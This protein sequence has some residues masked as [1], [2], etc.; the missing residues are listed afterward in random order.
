MSL[1]AIKAVLNKAR[2]NPR[3]AQVDIP[4][5]ELFEALSRASQIFLQLLAGKHS[6][7]PADVGC[8]GDWPRLRWV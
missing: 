8:S 5:T 7:P 6:G 3:L 2:V 4:G 1:Q